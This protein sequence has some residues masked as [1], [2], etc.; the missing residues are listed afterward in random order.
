MLI[1]SLLFFFSG[2]AALIYQVL[3][4]RYTGFIFG[5]TVYAAGTVITA[6]MIGLAIGARVFGR[7]APKLRRPVAMFGALEIAISAYALCMPYLFGQV[8]IAYRW[9][10]QNVSTDMGSLTLVRF[11]LAIGIMLVPTI[12]M[13]ATLPVLS[14]GLL[15]KPETFGKRLGWLY[16]I[17]TLGAVGGIVASGFFLIPLVGL[18]HTGFIA[19]GID[20]AV[21]VIGLILGLFAFKA[22]PEAVAAAEPHGAAAMPRGWL[23]ALWG[24]GLAG[25][26]ALASEILWFRALTL[27][28]G[29]TTYSFSAM[30]AVFLFGI[31]FG[32]TLLSRILDRV[33][34]PLLIFAL[35]QAGIGISTLLVMRL[36]DRMP[37]FLLQMLIEYGLSWPVMLTAQCLI[38]LSFLLV[39]TLLMGLSFTAVAKAARDLVPNA[40]LVV[41]RVYAANT[42]GCIAGSLFGSFVL[43][44]LGGIRLSLI[45][46]SAASVL[47]AVVYAFKASGAGRGARAVLAIAGIAAILW[48]FVMPPQWDQRLMATGVHFSPWNFIR[49]GKS[50]LEDRIQGERI[51]Y[52]KE[53]ITT[54]V[55]VG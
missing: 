45:W 14:Q 2:F 44:Q 43:L 9:F 38:A 20:F 25:F 11:G 55:S 50:I 8:Q 23:V 26:L 48:A 13:G 30:L 29:S 24:T 6:F 46:V 32:A 12:L 4:F 54:T 16:G 7:W 49:D 37:G 42:V 27:I 3:W 52:Y 39:P 35:C 22:E 36:F 28:F 18:L 51:L 53:G 1:L 31:G 47:L 34:S 41:S 17:N 15:T 21:G 5:N 33:K 10:Y 19:V 40:P